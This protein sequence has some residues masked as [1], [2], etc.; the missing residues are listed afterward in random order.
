M[1]ALS[2]YALKSAGLLSLFYLVYFLLLKND[3]N[4]K[5]NRRFLLSGIFAAAIL[6]AIQFKRTEI[7]PASKF[8]SSEFPVS[9][10]NAE[11]ISQLTTWNVW[12]VLGIFYLVVTLFFLLKMGWQLLSIRKL[13]IGNKESL[14]HKVNKEGH[15]RFIKSE[16]TTSPFSFFN[17][18]VYNPQLYNAEDLKIILQ[19]EKVHCRQHHSV[20]I[21]LANLSTALLWFNPL[22]WCYKKS[23]AQNLEFIADK[24]TVAFT[25]EK[26][27]YQR[28][29][30]KVSAKN[31]SPALTNNF[32]QSLIKKR[33]LMLNKKNTVRY[34][35][36][37]I[38]LVFPLILAFMLIFNVKTEART[39]T[40]SS[41]SEMLYKNA[42]SEVSATITQ[43]SEK[44]GL[45]K[46]A[47]L[48]RKNNIELQFKKL[49]Y[50][51]AGKLTNIKV[52]FL[53]KKN[54]KKGVYKAHDPNGIATFQIYI[55]DNE[56]GFRKASAMMGKN[57]I[58]A[59]GS[60]HNKTTEN[61]TSTSSA[62][63]K[64][65]K[66]GET[67]KKK[68]DKTQEAEKSEKPIYIL[69]G[70]IIKKEIVNLIDQ[71]KISSVNVLKDQAAVSLYGK[72]AKNGVVI[73]TTKISEE[74]EDS[75][76]DKAD[77]DSD[78]QKIQ[79]RL[80]GNKFEKKTDYEIL[81]G[82]AF[83]QD[84][85]AINTFQK[86]EE[87]AVYGSGQ[88]VKA[89]IFINGKRQP[90]PLV[91]LDGKKQSNSFKIEEFN[92]DNIAKINVLKGKAAIEKYG[93]EASNG[94]IEISTKKGKG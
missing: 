31:L 90:K 10:Q 51:K 35:F 66:S 58:S 74:N 45:D 39:N 26:K 57:T 79:I 42:Q 37:K 54:K 28:A 5:A 89:N 1:E 50:S 49:S 44:E 8:S 17:Y 81:E 63:G 43:F 30:L 19:H 29:M 60:H 2:L 11:D 78:F 14:S 22:S 76:L 18:I 88:E 69:N 55:K 87:E 24:E 6:P 32:Y 94:V 83:S 3:T 85:E 75:P 15:F 91:I 25:A 53:Q 46:V 27:K 40:P 68:I 9:P 21:L 93:K 16:L 62:K 38:S 72:S 73:I 92:A 23:I 86:Y 77:V 71:S 12:E 65:R 80:N 36:W 47:A 34:N 84:S 33:I 7:I 48:F 70:E 61:K 13:I 82:K 20:D 56:V 64:T 4:F 67:I 59:N 41:E 52:T